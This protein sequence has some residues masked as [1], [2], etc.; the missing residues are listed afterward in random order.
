MDPYGN[1][2][3]LHFACIRKQPDE[4]LMQAPGE[5]VSW[6]QGAV[7]AKDRLKVTV[8][9][10]ALYRDVNFILEARYGGEALLQDTFNIHTSGEGLQKAIRLELALGD[11]IPHLSEK[12]LFVRIN[13][14][15]LQAEGGDYLQGKLVASVRNMGKYVVM[16]DT[17]PP[18]VIPVKH[19]T[20]RHYLAADSLVFQITDNLSGINQYNAYI[21]NRWALFAY[22]A[23]SDRIEYAIDP[24][25]LDSGKQHELRIEVV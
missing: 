4:S 3:I 8:P 19:S 18:Q 20:T 12:L 9:P 16:Y 14:N 25:Y 21:D 10:G 2:S 13:G 24:E 22:D 1:Q 5:K 23:K 11:S 6:K 17:L 7:L 15:G